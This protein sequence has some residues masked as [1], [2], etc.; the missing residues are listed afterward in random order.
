MKPL[1]SIFLFAC[2]LVLTVNIGCKNKK[3][4]P[5]LNLASIDLARGELLLCGNGQF[6]EISFPLSCNNETQQAFNL[7]IALLHSF[8]Y[9]EAE[10]AFAKV[11]DADPECAMAY[12]G[13]AMSFYHSL[14]SP[15]TKKELEKGSKLLEIAKTLTKTQREQQYVDAIGAYYKDWDSVDH[16]TRSLLY[17]KKMET[18]YNNNKQDIEAAV[19]YALALNSTADPTDKSYA[20]Q[21]KAGKILEGLFPGHP[22]HPGIAHYLIHNYDYPELAERALSTARRYAEIAPASAHAQHMPS[23]IFTRL[24]LWDESIRSNLNSASS[25]RCYAEESQMAGHW[26]QEIHALDYLVYAYLQQGDN[27]KA[28]EQYKYL[29]TM[30]DVNP[31]DI[32]SAVYPF[33]A[34]PARI[35]LEN[36]QWA[37]AANIKPHAS[38]LDWEQFP[39][40][41]AIVHFARAIGSARSGDIVS[42]EKEADTLQ[43]LHEQLVTQV[44][45][46]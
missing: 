12:W 18:I 13:V 24:G 43:S 37:V 30:Y 41:K 3:A 35:A 44:S 11:I 29:K 26:N 38:E 40:Q 33:A 16:K 28:N 45:H 27:V 32:A 19:F 9:K 10:K 31:A 36:K 7:A 2:F 39:W 15:P 20:N 23:H 4:S 8:E 46:L 25:A 14:W 17:E 34:I 22:D 21:L 42:A 1:N 6:G 5:D